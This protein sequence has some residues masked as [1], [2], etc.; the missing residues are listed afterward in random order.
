MPHLT[1]PNAGE[2]PVVR[3]FRSGYALEFNLN[4]QPQWL[5]ASPPAGLAG[6]TNYTFGMWMGIRGGLTSGGSSFPPIFQCSNT[7]STT[8]GF[9]LS[10]H[11][12]ASP[13]QTLC[14]SAPGVNPNVSAR[15]ARAN[16]PD[17]EE[18]HLCGVVEGS[19][20]RIYLNGVLQNTTTNGAAVN[21]D[22]S[23]HSVAIGASVEG[24]RWIQVCASNL[25]IWNFALTT[26]QIQDWAMPRLT[27]TLPT[28]L[29][30]YVPM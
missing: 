2:R 27:G 21:S 1:Q 18:F 30:F 25:Q 9:G 22:L 6:A 19:A 7:N 5:N 13:G 23:A 20:V 15:F 12:T 14:M 26:Q 24:D 8:T 11:H 29:I 16:I 4:A 3:E 10:Y 28:G 17:D